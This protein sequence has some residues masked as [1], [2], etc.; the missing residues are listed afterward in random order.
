VLGLAVGDVGVV[1][2]I[3]ST[4]ESQIAINEILVSARVG[5]LVHNMPRALPT[6]RRILAVARSSVI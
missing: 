1:S 4:K 6:P 2:R 5:R 3:D